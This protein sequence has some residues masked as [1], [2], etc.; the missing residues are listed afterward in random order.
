MRDTLVVELQK[1]KFCPL[2]RRKW[3]IYEQEGKEGRAFFYC[4]YCEISIWIQDPMIPLW[5]TFEKVHCFTCRNHEMRFFCRMDGYC[6][7]YCKNCGCAIEQAE[8]GKHDG[9][10]KTVEE[11]KQE[12]KL[13]TRDIDREE[14]HG[15]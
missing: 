4:L 8:P 3:H 15:T 5:E 13:L 14:G 9:I 10:T 11:V 12:F 7:W 6:K 1:M 2:C